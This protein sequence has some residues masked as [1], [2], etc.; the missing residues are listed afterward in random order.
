MPRMRAIGLEA[1]PD[2]AVIAVPLG[3]LADAAREAV[4]AG[5]AVL[6]ENPLA[7]GEDVGEALVRHAE[8]AGAPHAPA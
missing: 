5:V 1:R 8:A 3:F 4:D 2:V 7:P 6:V